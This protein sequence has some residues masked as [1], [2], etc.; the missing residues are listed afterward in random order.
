MSNNNNGSSWAANHPLKPP[1]DIVQPS[2]ALPGAFGPLQGV[3]ALVGPTDVRNGADPK[4]MVSINA[5]QSFNKFYDNKKRNLGFTATI[6][7][8]SQDILSQYQDPGEGYGN[9]WNRDLSNF[10]HYTYF[11][12]KRTIIR[13]VGKKEEYTVWYVAFHSSFDP[14]NNNTMGQNGSSLMEEGTTIPL[15][16]PSWRPM[17]TQNRP[18]QSG[19]RRVLIDDR[20][21]AHDSQANTAKAIHASLNNFNPPV[22]TTY[23]CFFPL[24]RRPEFLED[25][26]AYIGSQRYNSKNERDRDAGNAWALSGAS[27]GMAVAAVVSGWPSVAYTGYVRYIAQGAVIVKGGGVED[28]AAQINFVEWVDEVPL[29][30]ALAA[31]SKFPL[32]I[33]NRDSFQQ[34]INPNKLKGVT[35]AM[36]N[37]LPQVVTMAMIEDG[38]PIW[39]VLTQGANSTSGNTEKYG[40]IGLAATA[41]EVAILA[42]YLWLIFSNDDGRAFPPQEAAD[43][44]QSIESYYNDKSNEAKRKFMIRQQERQRWTAAFTANPQQAMANYIKEIQDAYNSKHATARARVVQNN[45]E[46]QVRERIKRTQAQLDY[47]PNLSEKDRATLRDRLKSLHKELEQVR[48]RGGKSPKDSLGKHVLWYNQKGGDPHV[49]RTP[50]DFTENMTEEEKKEQRDAL[51]AAT[52]GTSNQQPMSMPNF[53]MPTHSQQPTTS[54]NNANLFNKPSVT[55]QDQSNTGQAMNILPDFTGDST[56]NEGDYDSENDDNQQAPRGRSRTQPAINNPGSLQRRST[57][58]RQKSKAGEHPK[59]SK[60]SPA[61]LGGSGFKLDKNAQLGG[62]NRLKK[63]GADKKSINASKSKFKTVNKSKSTFKKTP[64]QKTQ[65]KKSIL[66]KLELAAR[67]LPQFSLS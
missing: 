54:Y 38:M 51:K 57:T 10:Y 35:K 60:A 20:Y 27:L 3:Q 19:Q 33:P 62:S 2:G 18:G 44:L 48:V 56:D 15:L 55:W 50:I 40:G 32:I 43:M 8:M 65:P 13:G 66:D 45:L 61:A 7:E 1:K 49:A 24:V 28:V 52:S 59:V 42:M 39:E 17:I 67:M 46:Y 41:T 53:A 29:K 63:E 64:I 31:Q 21:L 6:G 26:N 4:A 22:G 58:V 9:A 12:V 25:V 5:F 11:P 16:E 37:I 30:T 23:L 47:A 34:P 36:Y 14:W